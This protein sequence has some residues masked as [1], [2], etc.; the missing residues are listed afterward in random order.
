MQRNDGGMLETA[1]KQ[2]I[3]IVIMLSCFMTDFKYLNTIFYLRYG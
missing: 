3:S 1:H 2:C